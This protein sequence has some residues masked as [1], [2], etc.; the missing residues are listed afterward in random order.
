MRQFLLQSGIT[1]FKGI[2]FDEL[3]RLHIDVQFAPSTGKKRS[4]K[5]SEERILV[6][7][8]I[9]SNGN[10]YVLKAV[11]QNERTVLEQCVQHINE[12]DPDVIEGYDLFGTILPA[13]NRGL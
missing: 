10:E 9:T 1:L 6:I 7:T 11:K 13:L 8:L 4:G 2:E 3:V 5:V 12:I